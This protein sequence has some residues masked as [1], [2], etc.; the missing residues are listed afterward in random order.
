LTDAQQYRL[1]FSPRVLPPG[2]W[3]WLYYKDWLVYFLRGVSGAFAYIIACRRAR[4]WMWLQSVLSFP[5]ICVGVFLG[6]TTPC[7]PVASYP[8]T[9]SLIVGS[10]RATSTYVRSNAMR[11]WAAAAV[12]PAS[13]QKPV[14][15]LLAALS[16]RTDWLR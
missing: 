16:L 13:D 8:G 14:K 10:P 12:T 7:Q 6:A 1:A 9:N 15:S 4:V 11:D 5:T 2:L 3:V